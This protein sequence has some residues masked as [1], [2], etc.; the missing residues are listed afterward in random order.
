MK[1]QTLIFTVLGLLLFSCQNKEELVLKQDAFQLSP[2]E[3]ENLCLLGHAGADNVT[4]DFVLVQGD[5]LYRRT[6][7]ENLEFVEEVIP[8]SDGLLAGER[9]LTLKRPNR[10]VAYDDFTVTG[11]IESNFGPVITQALVL[12]TQVWNSQLDCK[13]QIA[14]SRDPAGTDFTIRNLVGSSYGQACFPLNGNIGNLVEINE[15]AL[16]SP[17]N[18]SPACGGPRDFTLQEKVNI[19]VHEMGHI[20]GFLHADIFAGGVTGFDVCGNIL[21][22][23]GFLLHGTTPNDIT[24]IMASGPTQLGNCG[25]NNFNLADRRAAQLLYPEPGSQ[26]VNIPVVNSITTV[27]GDLRE[28][29]IDY[30]ISPAYFQVKICISNSGSPFRCFRGIGSD[31]T[32]Q[33]QAPA[34]ATTVRV[35]GLNYRG[36]YESNFNSKTVFF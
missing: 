26:I 25:V 22:G 6:E 29:K 16:N 4:E 3:E 31:D 20:L 30:P 34:G 36:D 32:F 24:S 27:S 7:L 9:Q 13:V 1:I 21:I 19:I 23:D 28:V 8:N 10:V 12:A 33:F 11:Y 35:S 18:F 15:V 2:A 5:I 14:L 17:V